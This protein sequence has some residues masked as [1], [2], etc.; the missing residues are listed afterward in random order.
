M[1]KYTMKMILDYIHGKEIDGYDIDVLEND[2]S[3][4]IEVMKVSSDKKMYNLCSDTVKKDFQF[5]KFLIQK[6][7]SDK[8][9][10]SSAVRTFIDNAEDELQ[11]LEILILIC[12]VLSEEDNE[13]LEFKTLLFVLEKKQEV[14]IECVKLELR[15]TDPA[16][17]RKMGETGFFIIYDDYN[18]SEVVTDFFA[19]IFLENLLDSEKYCFED[20]FHK[21][22]SSLEKLERTSIKSYLIEYICC[23][24]SMLAS[25]VSGHISVLQDTLSKIELLKRR[26]STYDSR[27][28][29]MKYHKLF[30]YIQR[31]M[32]TV[33]YECSYSEDEM[34]YFISEELGITSLVFRYDSSL[35]GDSELLE[36]ILGEVRKMDTSIMAYEDLRHYNNMKNIVI[37]F[38]DT[39]SMKEVEDID[40]DFDEFAVPTSPKII[41]MSKLMK[42]PPQKVVFY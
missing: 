20:F 17:L 34:L 4:V 13:Y 14:R 23:Y 2:P 19:K 25:Y 40:I 26:W 42:K 11:I 35:V 12:D 7:Y 32:E 18:S 38:L 1:G 28:E 16:L 27:L 33:E 29:S 9:F 31:Y 8:K 22:F 37:R 6:F 15:E 5:I 3:F 24:D 39:S 41:D 36:E 21:R 10:I 30:D